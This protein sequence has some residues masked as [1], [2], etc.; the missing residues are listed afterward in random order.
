MKDLIVQ[1]QEEEKIDLKPKKNR[2]KIK[3]I[4]ISIFLLLIMIGSY[5]VFTEYYLPET[6]EYTISIYKENGILV[7]DLIYKKDSYIQLLNDKE[8]IVETINLNE[9]TEE[10]ILENQD[11]NLVIDTWEIEKKIDEKEEFY[12]RNIIYFNIRP[13]YK[14]KEDYILTFKTADD[15][16]ELTEKDTKVDYIKVPY[17][18]E[19]TINGYLPEVEVHKDF[20][21]DWYI[22]NKKIDNETKVNKDTEIIFKTYQDKNN[23]FID[24]YTEQFTIK[25]N[26]NLKQQVEDKVVKWEET[27]K[28]PVLEDE[29]KVFYGWYEDEEFNKEFTEKTKVTKDMTI[30]AKIRTFEEVINNSVEDPIDRKDIQLQL[31]RMLVQRN[32]LIDELYKGMIEQENKAREEKIKKNRENNINEQPPVQ[33]IKLYNE[34]HNKVFLV[35]FLNPSS[36]Y[37]YSI[38]MPYGQTLKIVNEKGDLIKEYGIRQDTTIVLDD[39]KLV[40]SEKK[41][42]M[43]HTE[44]RQINETVF[45]KLQP[46]TK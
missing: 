10:M 34:K 21:G 41:L 9:A 24:D 31:K 20:K 28:L 12:K 19:T 37:I 23:N 7:E 26:T 11:P 33:I 27:I 4:V 1:S 8:E 14:P 18:K 43:Y 42:D 3:I 35:T 38:A 6:T 45:V 25:F 30:Y 44:Y 29:T 16:A 22:G 2:K 36:E 17:K 15:K 32:N 40:T 13:K 39:K 46:L 5:I